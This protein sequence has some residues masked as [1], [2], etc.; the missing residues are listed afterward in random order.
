[1]PG[2]EQDRQPELIVYVLKAGARQDETFSDA[3]R[4]LRCYRCLEFWP[5]DSEFFSPA[6]KA[7]TKP[8]KWCKACYAAWRADRRRLCRN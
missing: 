8:A 7:H 4:E 6:D 2:V 5:A 3:G 1:M